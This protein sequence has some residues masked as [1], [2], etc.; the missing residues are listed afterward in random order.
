MIR[1]RFSIVILAQVEKNW[2][3]PCHHL[4]KTMFGTEQ[5]ADSVENVLPPGILEALKIP[6]SW[7]VSTSAATVEDALGVALK[8]S[9]E[10]K[11]S[12]DEQSVPSSEENMLAAILSSGKMDLQGKVGKH[13]MYQK[14]IDEQLKQEWAKCATKD[15]RDAVRMNWVKG[16]LDGCVAKRLRTQKATFENFKKGKFK[17][18]SVIVRDEGS[19]QC[20]VKAATNIV[21]TCIALWKKNITCNG[22]PFVSWNSF[23]KRAE[24]LHLE[25]GFADIVQDCWKVMDGVDIDLDMSSPGQVVPVDNGGGGNPKPKKG[26]TQPSS[27][28]GKPTPTP[29]PAATPQKPVKRK[30]TS[31]Q[32]PGEPPAEDEEKRKAA[33]KEIDAKLA[34]CVKAKLSM[35]SACAACSDVLG[36][37]SKDTAWKWADNDAVLQPLRKARSK[38]EGLKES[39]FWG[40][41][42]LHGKA[43]PAWARKN[44]D[45]PALKKELLRLEEF[46]RKVDVLARRTDELKA[47]HCQRIDDISESQ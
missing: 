6:A 43:F 7:D 30:P 41:L 21:Q 34:K 22:V 25:T 45:V 31:P 5:T 33:K 20:A 37:I 47:M 32:G 13:F 10:G 27:S 36:L 11:V 28:G 42:A 19:D 46:D 23:S 39:N 12:N 17:P 3:V 40:E 16:K 44:F 14:S 8:P 26:I 38:V 2:F 15:Q 4:H 24:F 18:F 29:T 1:I 9:I 35:D